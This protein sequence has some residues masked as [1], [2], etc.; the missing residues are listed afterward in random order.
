MRPRDV[1][2]LVAIAVA[3]TLSTALLGGATRWAAMIASALALA[4]AVPHLS[5]RR[6]A[7]RPGPLLRLVGL[8]AALTAIQLVPLPEMIAEIL[9]RP[10]LEL[11]YDHAGA[12][13]EA[14]PT[15]TVA[16]YDPPATLVEL[17]KLCGY[18]ALAW[19]AG[20]LAAQRRSRPWL[21]AGVVGAAAIA[22]V[23]GA[24]HV[25]AGAHHLYGVFA[26]PPPDRVTGPLINDNHFAALC[27]L[28]APLALGLALQ[29][30]GRLRA[31]AALAGLVLTAATL[32]SGSRGGALALGAGLA[33][34][35]L[36]LVL[37]RRGGTDDDRGRPRSALPA[38][39]VAGSI[40]LLLGVVVMS[41]VTTELRSVRLAELSEPRSKYQVWSNALPLV[42][43]NRWLGIGK[44]AFETTYP[45][46][47]PVGDV[48]FSHAENSYLQAVVDWGVPGAAGLTVL[49]LLLGREAL[50]R[51]RNG[52]LEA[53]ALGGLTAIALHDLVD[54]SLELPAV[55]MATICVA[56]VVAPTRT[57]TDAPRGD[58]GDDG[59]SRRPRLDPRT[60][61]LRLAA[62][63]VAA[64]V[65]VL[66]A[67]PLGRSAVSDRE[68]LGDDRSGAGAVAA[69]R[70]ILARHPADGLAAGHAAQAL[71]AA[72][73][74]RAVPVVSRAL[75]LRPHHP[76]LHRLAGRM[77]AASQRPRQAQIELRLALA[78]ADDREASTILEEIAALF[79]DPAEAARAL[80]TEER[81]SWRLQ[82][83]LAARGRD[84]LAV[85]YAAR[86]VELEPGRADAHL[87]LALAALRLGQPA[88]AREHAEAAHALA[89]T[90]LTALTV[91]RARAA[92]GDHLGAVMALRD[93]PP[94]R[95]AIL[96]GDLAAEL[97]AH[98]RA[99]GD[100]EGARQ[101]LLDA[102]DAAVQP[103]TEA[104][105]RR[106]YAD[107]EDAL[108]N[109]NRATYERRRADELSPPRAPR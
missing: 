43:E 87:D 90:T 23:I 31:A 96:A 47:A 80:P 92:A 62:V 34:T 6:T 36:L 74:P 3:L 24:V 38:V 75:A 72:R 99:T 100:L 16:S 2:A 91:A 65:I 7:S 15:W 30:G 18:L 25:A 35:T 5:S 19:T 103:G 78:W 45:Q 109:K 66:A 17:A 107:I 86:V 82:K 28:A 106:P 55:A 42:D 13:G 71:F 77:L 4:V 89:P 14:R 32:L 54:F 102:I 20:R 41:D 29:W 21:A 49:L 39:V 56:A 64:L 51:W 8:A 81:Q 63:G 98:L 27:A 101:V 76:G 46:A 85:A 57:G 26:E 52:P 104:A 33:V 88:V 59:G 58:G 83:L 10:R 95:D 44:G 53:G 9:A 84:A 48:T 69:A 79:P 73:D 105:L 37:Q 94:T 97:A 70:R 11:A 60:R 1:V 93:A 22:V 108:G 68:R 67:S 61:G 50:R 40:A 12:F